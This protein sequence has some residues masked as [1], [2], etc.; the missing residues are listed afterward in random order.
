MSRFLPILLALAA[1]V[2]PIHAQGVSQQNPSALAT[3]RAFGRERGEAQL[4]RVVGL[5]G[6]NGQDQPAQWLILQADVEVSG[7]LHEYALQGG[8]V[9]AQRSFRRNPNQDLPNIPLSLPKIVVDSPQAF[10]LANQAARKAGVGFDS[11]NFQLRCRDL[12]NEP[13]WVL[14]LMDEGRRTVG[15][16]YLSAVTGEALRAVWNPPSSLTTTAPAERTS[17]PRGIIPQLVDRI[18]E[19]QS[20]NAGF[21][22]A[23][24]YLTP[25]MPDQPPKR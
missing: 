1:G 23:D 18:S 5:V 6:F 7:W 10:A 15:V 25:G 24:A 19:R 17:A 14:S 16:V 4:A 22:G 2:S 20:G 11:M 8:R 9:V 21:P 12:R 13:V 3:L